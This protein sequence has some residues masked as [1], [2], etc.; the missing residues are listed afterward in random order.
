MP[1][2]ILAYH[3]GTKPETPEDGA[4]QRARFMEWMKSVG[5]AMVSPA[6]PVGPSRMVSRDG[7]QEADGG[8]ALTGY[9]VIA[10]DSLEKAVTIAADCPFAEIGTI[11]VAELMKMG[12]C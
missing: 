8:A 12:S 3:G 5:D 9:S 4:R 10:A 1:N 6:N 2:Y 11:E 7:V